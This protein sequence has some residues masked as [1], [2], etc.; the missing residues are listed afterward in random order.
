MSQLTWETTEDFTQLLD[1]R[2]ICG[3][4]LSEHGHVP[5]WTL[6]TMGVSQ[7]VMFS[8]EMEQITVPDTSFWGNLFGRKKLVQRRKRCNCK[9]F[10]EAG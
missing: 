5:F 4:K 9:R 8:G 10:Q 6:K 3:H 7:C 2:C 1:K